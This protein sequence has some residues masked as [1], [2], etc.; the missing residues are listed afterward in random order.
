MNNDVIRSTFWVPV[1][2]MTEA[3][4]SAR[5]IDNIQSRFGSAHTGG[6]NVVLGDG[7]VRSVNYNIDPNIWKFSGSIIDTNPGNLP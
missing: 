7:S 1:K 4:F 2:D 3:D 6:I 5:S